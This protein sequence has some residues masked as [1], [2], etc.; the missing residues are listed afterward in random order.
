MRPHDTESPLHVRLPADVDRPD[1]VIAGMTWR[2]LVIATVTGLLIYGTWTA[3]A[4]TVQPLIFAVCALPVA[5]VGFILAVGRRDGQNLDAWLTAAWRHRR[6]PHHL[7]PEHGRIT[8]APAW[9]AATS[10]PG[11]PSPLRLPAKGV[12]PDGLID[13][14]SDGTT[15]LLRATPVPFGLRT[16]T[17]QNALVARFGGWLNSLDGP[18]QILVRSQRIDLTALADRV[19][20]HAPGLPHPALEEAA[21]SHAAFLDDLATHRE[22]LARQITVAVRDKRGPVHTSRR[23]AG[24]ARALAAC[25]V[26]AVVADG[27][28]A[29][30]LLASC[31]N[32]AAL[33]VNGDLR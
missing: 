4:T 8:A 28:T 9:I 19:A 32:P 15:A 25:E 3:V 13:L 6:T 24:A 23:A 16:T 12:R 11:P 27:D 18:T 22:L 2:Q 10:H 14:A 21:R 1:R 29:A 5:G 33:P 17:E 30:A 20:D 26:R 7:V 31:L